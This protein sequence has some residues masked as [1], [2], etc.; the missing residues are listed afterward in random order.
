MDGWVVVNVE[1]GISARYIIHL[2]FEALSESSPVMIGASEN[3]MYNIEV[4]EVLN[5]L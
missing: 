1:R 2:S 4:E 3:C 5:I